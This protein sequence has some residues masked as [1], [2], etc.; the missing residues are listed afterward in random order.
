MRFKPYEF[1]E[2][3]IF[4]SNACILVNIVLSF[5]L[6]FFARTAVFVKTIETVLSLFSMTLILIGKS[7]EISGSCSMS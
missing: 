3:T 7:S 5:S 1:I 6:Y 4:S 2:A